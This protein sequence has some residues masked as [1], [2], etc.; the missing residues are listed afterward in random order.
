MS[1]PKDYYVSMLRDKR[2]ALLAGPFLT[3]DE[4]LKLV[5]PAKSEARR[6]DPFTDFDAFGTCSMPRRAENKMGWLNVYLGVKPRELAA[7]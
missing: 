4:A 7:A 5:D 2:Y 1:E 6:L 3:H